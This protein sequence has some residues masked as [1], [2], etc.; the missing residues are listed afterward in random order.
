[1][2][3]IISLIFVIGISSC[4]LAQ[5]FVAKGKVQTDSCCYRNKSNCANV[6]EK[7]SVTDS[8]L[9]LCK[10]SSDSAKISRYINSKCLRERNKRNSMVLY[11]EIK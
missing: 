6:K 2:K 5:G 11:S 7:V 8:L 1:M 10:D 9:T 4:L 3:K